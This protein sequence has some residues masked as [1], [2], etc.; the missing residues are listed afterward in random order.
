[1][2]IAS[3]DQVL[4]NFTGQNTVNEELILNKKITVLTISDH[5]LLP[6]GVGTQTKYVIEA[7]LRTGKFKVISLGGA[8]KHQDYTPKKV[9]QFGDDWEIFPIDGYGNAQIV[10]A[11]INDRKPDILYFM[12]DPRFYEWLW[13]IDDSIRENVPMIYYHVWDNY[14]YPK[15]NQRYYESN[16]VIASISKVTSDIVRTV[17]PQVEEYYVPHAVDSKIFNKRSTEEIKKVL[18][19]NPPLRDRFVFFWNNRN[20]RRKQTGSLLYWFRDFLELPE[21]DKD[22]VCLFLHTDPNDPHGQPLQYLTEELGFKEG[23]VVLSTNKL[24]SEQMSMLYNIADCTVNISDA[25]GFGLATL[26]SL[27][28]GTP[29]IVNMTGGLQEQ[30]TD[31]EQWF[32]IGIQPSSKAVIGSQNVPYIYEDRISKEDFLNALLEMYQKTPEQRRQLGELGQEHVQ[33]NYS[34]EAFNKQWVDIM[35]SIHE[36]HGS[37][38]TRKNYKNIRVEIL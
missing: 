13:A 9:E 12:T 34:F 16:D 18:D 2:L 17:A 8:V 10:N 15:F 32:G 37:W 4:V 30:V 31:G 26:E 36:N 21:V 29:I 33:Q 28:C 1:V 27:S 19:N 7:L 5:P 38:E 14:P 3:N 24:P 23:E 20:A 25:E 22:K 6:S 35:T 11:F